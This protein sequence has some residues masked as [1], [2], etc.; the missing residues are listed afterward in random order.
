M[1]CFIWV[2]LDVLFFV[3]LLVLCV[4]CWCYFFLV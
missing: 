3:G 4:G 1:G 2:V